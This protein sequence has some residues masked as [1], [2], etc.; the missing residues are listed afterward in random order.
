MDFGHSPDTLLRLR[1]DDTLLGARE[2][3]DLTGNEGDDVVD[4]GR[5]SGND[6]LGGNDGTDTCRSDPDDSRTGCEF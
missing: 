6:P 2:P 4:S 1:G 3:D 5:E